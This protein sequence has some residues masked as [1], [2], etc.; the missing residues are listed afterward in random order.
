M[1]PDRWTRVA[2]LFHEALDRPPTERPGF[3]AAACGEDADLRAE[4]AAMLEADAGAGGLLL[5]RVVPEQ[6]APGSRLGAYRIEGLVGAGGMGEVYRATRADGA[7]EQTVAI[8]LLRPDYR[9]AEAIHRFRL[10]RQLL[11]RLVHPEIA[12]LVDGGTA[13]DG[14]P[15]LVLQYVD[16]LPITRYVAEHHLPLAAR[17]RLLVRVA[18]VVQFAHGRLIVHRDLK[19]SNIQILP[20]GSPRLLDFGI[21]KLLDPD[22]AEG[23]TPVTRPETRLLTP[24]H[25]APE[26]LRREPVGTATDVYGL[27]ALLYELQTGRRPFG[28]GGR[29]PAQ[30]EREILEQDPL[31]PSRAVADPALSRA[32]RGDLDRITLM[33]LRK[34]PDRRY[35]SAGEFADDLERHLAGRPVR[36]ERDTLRYRA[37]KFAG[38][39]RGWLLA[40][41]AG[42]ILVAGFMASLLWQNRQ[43]TRAR[44]RAE[45]ERAVAEDVVGMMTELFEQSNPEVVPGGDT[46]RVAAFLDLAERGA[47]A[48]RADPGRQAQMWRVLGN[49]R[50]SRGEYGRAADLLRRAL[51]YADSARG[52]TDPLGARIYFELAQVV[53]SLEGSARGAAMLDSAVTRLRQAGGERDS[54]LALALY[55]L[56][57]V[58]DDRRLQWARFDSAIRMQRARGTDSLTIAGALDAQGH[59]FLGRGRP[60]EAL[61]S[62]EGSLRLLEHLVPADHPYRL[63]E[64]NNVASALGGLGDWARAE[65]LV[66]GV[67]AVD[68]R[69]DS[70]SEA[71]GWDQHRLALLVANQ[72]R[73]REAEALLVDALARLRRHLAPDHVALA[74]MT[75]DLAIVIAA[76]GR[77]R[78]GLRL[79]DSTIARTARGEPT[80]GVTAAFF[81]LQRGKLL[82]RLGRVDEADRAIQAGARGVLAGT[83]LAHPYRIQVHFIRGLLALTQGE[84]AAAVDEFTATREGRG[85]LPPGHPER[86]GGDCA[87]GIA[88]VRQ[89][90]TDEGTR[91]MDRC[92]AYARW[93]LAEPLLVRWSGGGGAA[94]RP[95]R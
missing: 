19:P 12:A 49:V 6:L 75:R 59:A 92:A 69:Q 72:G 93:G 73:L 66:R 32:L 91:L 9:S 18:R 31:P 71:V 20:D 38:R 51:R 68:R 65:S 53:N 62:F 35:G 67:G 24:E 17:L 48:L 80:P 95:V 16:G 10:E 47:A 74:S 11:A 41:A 70:T 28:G 2:D 55:R 39:N 43:V 3:L 77:T 5:E 45:A 52:P 37:R 58:T 21:A 4:V 14:R 46:M 33:A 87:L 83:P 50:G 78:E 42:L 82:L 40:G 85:Q 63:T 86:L 60:A 8:K 29:S 22:V 36:A 81:H 90:R 76:Q 1:D 23:A 64:T 15:Y 7:Y 27:G 57:F 61:A 79:L 44:D 34:E 54:V 89:G 56:A 84:P 26:Q 30:L 88:L 94:P 13:P 25:A